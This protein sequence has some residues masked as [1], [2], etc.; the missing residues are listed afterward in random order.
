MITLFIISCDASKNNFG[1]V[2]IDDE[3]AEIL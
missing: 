2:S 3:K 1:Y